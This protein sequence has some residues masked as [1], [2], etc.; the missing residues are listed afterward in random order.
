MGLKELERGSVIAARRTWHGQGDS[1]LSQVQ[2]AGKGIIFTSLHPHRCQWGVFPVH[3]EHKTW[4]C[5]SVWPQVGGWDTLI[6]I[7]HCQ[8]QNIFKIDSKYMFLSS[9]PL[10]S[11][12]LLL[13]LPPTRLSP[14]SALPAKAR[15]LHVEQWVCP[16]STKGCAAPRPGAHWLWGAGTGTK[17]PGLSRSWG[18]ST[19]SKQF[20]ANE[21]K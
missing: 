9:S 7:H 5:L 16:S 4:S 18:Q 3:L 8:P 12:H 6:K 11:C 10:S 14:C 2:I 21:V 1:H 19:Q 20:W 13:L 15:A 17:S